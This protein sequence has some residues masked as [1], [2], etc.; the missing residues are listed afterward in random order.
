MATKKTTKSAKKAK[1]V[2]PEF[3]PATTH[4]PELP[5]VPARALAALA[6][7]V[8]KA[9]DVYGKRDLIENLV[10]YKERSALYGA[11]LRHSVVPF[12]DESELWGQLAELREDD[13][14]A[15]KPADV[16]MLLSKITRFERSKRDKT[17]RVLP[18]WPKALDDLAL[19]A[20]LE[21]PSAFAGYSDWAEPVKKGFVTVLVRAGALPREALGSKFVR[22]LAELHLEGYGLPSRPAFVQDGAHFIYDEMYD[23]EQ[24]PAQDFWDFVSIFTSKEAFLSALDDAASQPSFLDEHRSTLMYQHIDVLRRAPIDR[25]AKHL[26]KTG[27]DDSSSRKVHALLEERSDTPAELFS[28]ARQ[29]K[30]GD[31]LKSEV[32]LVRGLLRAKD[33]GEAIDAD[34][35]DI[36]TFASV[37]TGYK[38]IDPVLGVTELVAALRTLGHDRARDIAV[39]IASGEYSLSN[40]FPVLHAF[41]EERALIDLAFT[42]LAAYAYASREIYVGISLFPKGALDLLAE[43]HDQVLAQGGAARAELVRRGIQGVLAKLAQNGETWDARFDRFLDVHGFEVGIDGKPSYNV[44]SDYSNYIAPVVLVAV[45]GLSP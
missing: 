42:R 15:I 4:L 8:K 33:R 7:K 12:W 29:L 35:D 23:K 37:Q 2:E 41:V 10:S 24:H 13:N 20:Y 16:A 28:L 30:E 1:P 21:D 22:E 17:T 40:V 39:R 44:D 6:A 25:L 27:L 45:P 31:T 32:A 36:F 3:V 5:D 43:K 14:E 38:P 11:L 26:S 19:P 18:S 34:I 9:K